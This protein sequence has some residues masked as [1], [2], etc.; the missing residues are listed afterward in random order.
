MSPSDQKQ[1][2]A[3]PW[4]EEQSIKFGESEVGYIRIGAGGEL[5]LNAKLEISLGLSFSAYLF[6]LSVTISA[7]AIEVSV[8]ADFEAGLHSLSLTG[9]ISEAKLTELEQRLSAVKATASVIRNRVSASETSLK[10]TQ[11]LASSTYLLH[12]D[13]QAVAQ[14]SAAVLNHSAAMLTQLENGLTNNAVAQAVNRAEAITKT[15]TDQRILALANNSEVAIN[16]T[17][18]EIS[19]MESCADYIV[20]GTLNVNRAELMNL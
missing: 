17:A 18:I 2:E 4:Y 14:E 3:K 1:A 10:S 16:N 9:R 7:L 15:I 12:T 11:A 19:K 13:I 5:W 6:I 8:S 20:S